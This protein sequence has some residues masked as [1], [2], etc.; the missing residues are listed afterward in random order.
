M[1]APGAESSGSDQS[2][3]VTTLGTTRSAGAGSRTAF[4]L[5][6]A[7]AHWVRLLQDAGLAPST[8]PEHRPTAQ[9]VGP[10][11]AGE[12]WPD[13]ADNNSGPQGEEGEGLGSRR[14]GP[15]G[16]AGDA[17]SPNRHDHVRPDQGGRGDAG[18]QGNQEARR[19]RGDR[20][21]GDDRAAQD[22]PEVV[23]DREVWES[24]TPRSGNGLRQWP[25]GSSRQHLRL[26]VSGAGGTG[27]T[28]VGSE[29]RHGGAPKEPARGLPGNETDAMGSDRAGSDRVGSQRHGSG[30]TGDD[31]DPRAGAG[32]AVSTPPNA[33]VPA[34]TRQPR[35]GTAIAAPDKHAGYGV[36]PFPSGSVE[37]GG[38]GSAGSSLGRRGRGSEAQAVP[39]VS[40]H[41]LTAP[42]L[43]VGRPVER[44]R[45]PLDPAPAAD[46]PVA[47]P[48]PHPWP[49]LPVHAP[50]GPEPVVA[51]ASALRTMARTARLADEQA[52]V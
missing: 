3:P 28:A 4:N 2:T 38:A 22:A 12:E 5:D 52:A 21:V 26:I 50:A 31:A 10:D 39:P 9:A 33:S 42:L 29:A 45:W 7:P 20:K 15:V 44:D 11:S 16:P 46:R 6:G 37:S 27:G 47:P 32:R 25:P 34:P 18:N 30:S 14:R 24:A 43:P 41:P 36:A 8:A 48:M 13:G 1:P 40:E 49:E 51:A 35:H 19:A 23:D 17:V